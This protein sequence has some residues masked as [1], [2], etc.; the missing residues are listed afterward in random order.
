MG[1]GGVLKLSMETRKN[2]KENP[3]QLGQKYFL[4]E[5]GK[6]HAR[7]PDRGAGSFRFL[8]GGFFGFFIYLCTS[9]AAP[10]IPLCRRMLGSNPGY[11][12]LRHWLSDALYSHSATSHPHSV[13]SHPQLGYI[14]SAIRQH[15][16]HSR[17]H[18]IHNSATSH[19]QSATSHPP[20]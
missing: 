15:L 1:G 9:S 6:V 7:N 11:W 12:R 17:L 13:I 10:Q 14:S 3:M 19:P 4:T 2:H 16:I 20:Y 18:L 5:E 8:T